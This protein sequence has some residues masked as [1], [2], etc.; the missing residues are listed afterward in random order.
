MS[1]RQRIED[2]ARELG[3]F[4][5]PENRTDRQLLDAIQ[6]EQAAAAWMNRFAQLSSDE[7][8]SDAVRRLRD[9]LTSGNA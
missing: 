6:A 5:D 8:K 7:A 3:C 2:R 9:E 1:T 4:P